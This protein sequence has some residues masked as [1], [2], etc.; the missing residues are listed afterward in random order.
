M[1]NNYNEIKETLDLLG[2]HF[3]LA[4]A[5]GMG[6][7]LEQ[8]IELLLEW[9]AFAGLI[10]KTDEEHIVS[11]HVVDS[12]SLVR[13]LEGASGPGDSPHL[14]IGAGG[15]FPAI[16]MAIALPAMEF[17]AVERSARKSTFLRKAASDLSL[18][19]LRIIPGMFPEKVL[20]ERPSTIT[21]RA[22]ENPERIFKD[23][24]DWLPS[25][26]TFLCQIPNPQAHL[27]AGFD[28][29][30][31]RDAWTEK[32]YRRGTLHLIRRIE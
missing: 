31:V 7:K 8:Y 32:G 6:S 4:V 16:P 13:V 11:R 3:S 22:V 27:P 14:D 12:L 1:D 29:V 18:S 25:G 21:A 15:G 26:C 17:I 10:S 30:V 5:E 2:E 20:D 28:C 19:N 23:I 9:N 24:L